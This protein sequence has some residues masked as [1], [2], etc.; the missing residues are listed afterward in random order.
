MKQYDFRFDTALIESFIGKT[1][2]KYK[3]AEFMYTNSV[4]AVLDFEIEDVVYE[5]TN[6]FEAMD[7]LT[8][9]GEATIF[10]ISKTKWN[11]VDSM[12]N[13]DIHYDLL[14][15]KPFAISSMCFC[16]RIRT[17]NSVLS[18]PKGELISVLAL[19]V[20]KYIYKKVNFGA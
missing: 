3:H 8:L 19:H 6:E 14:K 10:R 15:K 5:L 18:F 11:N 7:F 9:D 13:N 12:I 2:T 16:G 17:I 4:T 1:L 20:S